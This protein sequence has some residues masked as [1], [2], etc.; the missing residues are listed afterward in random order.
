MS[1]L[2][3]RNIPGSEPQ[4]GLVSAGSGEAYTA[5][6]GPQKGRG[7]NY[8]ISG[9]LIKTNLSY[10]TSWLAAND[11]DQ[12]LILCAVMADQLIHEKLVVDIPHIWFNRQSSEVVHEINKLSIIRA[13]IERHYRNTVF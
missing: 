13:I 5:L 6:R 11:I 9:V 4:E 3:G 8:K 12:F 1:F 10:L 2:F 7:L